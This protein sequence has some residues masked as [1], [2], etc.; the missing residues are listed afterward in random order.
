MNM[1][2]WGYLFIAL[3]LLTS[4]NRNG[5]RK[6]QKKSHKQQV[7]FREVIDYQ[8]QDILK[9]D[10]TCNNDIMHCTHVRIEYPDFLGNYATIPNRLTHD[11]ITYLLYDKDMGSSRSND[12]KKVTQDFLFDYY[13]FKRSFPSVKTVWYFKLK[14]EPIYEHDSL[15]CFAFSSEKYHGGTHAIA[16]K[17]F[18]TINRYTGKRFWPLNLISDIDTFKNIAEKKFRKLKG[19]NPDDNLNKAGYNFDNNK[20]KLPS[21]IGLNDKGF[22]LRYNVYEIAPYA[23]GPTEFTIG[24]KEAGIK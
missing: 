9:Q 3:M 8:M 14:S 4:C 12:L 17:Y 15:L 13:M 23:M 6:T 19:L 24:F 11:L 7:S 21:N 5:E 16:G 1:K 20:F 22:V 18:I 10:T 2:K